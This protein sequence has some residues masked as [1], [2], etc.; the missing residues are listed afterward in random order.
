M[1]KV[2]YSILFWWGSFLI[3]LKTITCNSIL[4]KTF[5]HYRLFARIF[6]ERT[7]LRT[8]WTAASASS[9]YEVKVIHVVP[10]F[11]VVSQLWR[12]WENAKIWGET[13]ECKNVYEI[14]QQQEF[15]IQ[16]IAKAQFLLIFLYELII[17]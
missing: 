4:K 11:F 12:F 6:L 16:I 14:T 10:R 8:L 17:S 7:T 13:T 15:H 9:V 5:F 3:R 1:N 2:F